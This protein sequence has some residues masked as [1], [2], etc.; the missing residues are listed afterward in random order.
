MPQLL[1]VTILTFLQCCVKLHH[2]H[3]NKRPRAGRVC[4]GREAMHQQRQE[5]IEPSG[6]AGPL[7]P[8]P[9]PTTTASLMGQ[10]NGWHRAHSIRVHTYTRD[11][12]TKHLPHTSLSTR[13]LLPLSPDFFFFFFFFC[14][15]FLFSLSWTSCSKA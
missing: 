2:L 9:T 10:T 7:T 15:L 4:P 13:L 1:A 8:P 11:T 6:Q 5:R 14:L 3:C 12:H